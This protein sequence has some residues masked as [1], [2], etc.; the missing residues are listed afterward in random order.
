MIT[1][2]PELPGG[3]EAVARLS[4]AG[5]VVA[6]GH[7]GADYE[8][9]RQAI[10]AG[11]RFGTHLYNAMRGFH[12]RQPGLVG[13]VLLDERAT[14]GLIADGEHLHEATCEQVSQLKPA[15]KIALTTDQTA[16]A[17]SPR[18]RY[19]LGGRTIVTDGRAARLEDGTLAGSV[20]TMDQLVRRMARLP[21]I[22]LKQAVTMATASPAAVLGDGR[23]GRL[24]A[25]AHADLVI[26]DKE[27][28]VRLTMV[29]GRVV[30]QR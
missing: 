7:S 21:R 17:G 12:H 15:R 25:G 4:A 2:A 3:L 22:S 18:G 8:Q 9:G 30:F 27:M 10:E 29:G 19:L 1:V 5:V 13:A 6:A 16:G 20:A 28:R 14:V 23:L 24:R 11:V 26:L